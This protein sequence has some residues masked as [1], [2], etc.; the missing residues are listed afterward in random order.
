MD[1]RA[2]AILGFQITFLTFAVVMLNA[3]LDKYVLSEWQWA[4]DLELPVGRMMMFV[5]AAMLMLALAPIRR[6]CA[7]LLAVPIA[8]G[9]RREVLIGIGLVL[10]VDFAVLGGLALWNWTV[11]GEPRLARVMGAQSGDAEAMHQATSTH[12]IVFFALFATTLGPI[13][14]ELVFRG[15]LYPA[16]RD[17]WGWI[18]GSVGTA[19]VFGLFHGTFWPQF[20]GSFVFVCV[21]RKTGSLRAAIYVHAAGNFLLWYPM[22]GQFML[23]A[24]RS[25]GELHLW[26]FHLVCLA[27]AVLLL[28]WYVW[29]ARDSR[30]PAE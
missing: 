23:P 1:R 11:G 16:W 19:V 9:T 2:S 7:M 8:Q 25:T 15:M 21:L 22:L 6:L 18:L 14:E 3:P 17:A 12:G 29:S 20:L 26:T 4:L 5:V 24:V 13:I 28:P 27:G 30:L 10:L